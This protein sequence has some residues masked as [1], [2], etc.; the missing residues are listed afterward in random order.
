MATKV[1]AFQSW[2]MKAVCP[3]VVAKRNMIKLLKNFLGPIKLQIKAGKE[4]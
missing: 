4:L 3:V 2:G 1:T